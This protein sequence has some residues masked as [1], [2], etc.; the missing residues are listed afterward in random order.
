M[1]LP[2]S[3]ACAVLL[4]ASGFSP[5]RAAGETSEPEHLAALVRQLDLIDRLAEHAA[6]VSAQDRARYHFDY[7]RLRDDIAR[8]RAGVQGY[9]VPP[10]AQPRDLLPLAGEYRIT[11][12][13]PKDAP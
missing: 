11:Q 5:V 3:L 9:L 12:P 8:V 10:R 4:V 7:I 13:D 1:F 2:R 6:K